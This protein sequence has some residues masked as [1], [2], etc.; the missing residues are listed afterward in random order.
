MHI[1]AYAYT[2]ICI[3]VSHLV[4]APQC[5]DRKA[6]R[7]QRQHQLAE[8]IKVKLVGDG[9]AEDVDSTGEQSARDKRCG[10]VRY[11]QQH[12]QAC[13]SEEHTACV[14]PAAHNRQLA[15]ARKLAVP[16]ATHRA[17]PPWPTRRRRHPNLARGVPRLDAGVHARPT[18]SMGRGQ[19]LTLVAATFCVPSGMHAALRGSRAQR[20]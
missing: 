5:R 16:L 14:A 17:H 19:P 1:R 3:Y 7:E 12:S 13:P 9:E 20:T 8:A 10:R 18:A 11:E 15:H 2:C 6:Q 4:L